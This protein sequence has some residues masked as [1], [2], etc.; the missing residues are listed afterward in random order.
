MLFFGLILFGFNKNVWRV[1]SDFCNEVDGSMLEEIDS[2]NGSSF[3]VDCTC[4]YEDK[5]YKQGRCGSD[6]LPDRSMSITTPGIQNISSAY[7]RCSGFIMRIVTD[8]FFNIN[9]G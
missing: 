2:R 6:T 8:V 1:I 4:V 7:S 9:R 3:R 5:A